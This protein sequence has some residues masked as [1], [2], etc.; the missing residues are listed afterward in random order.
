MPLVAADE[1][2]N[3]AGD[4]T[5]VCPAS[6]R[7]YAERDGALSPE[8]AQASSPNDAQMPDQTREDQQ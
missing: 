1:A 2:S 7:R 3:E 5:W 6:G 4:R 8:E